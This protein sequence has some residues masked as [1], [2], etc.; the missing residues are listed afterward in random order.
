MW[1]N[2]KESQ[3]QIYMTPQPFYMNLIFLSNDHSGQRIKDS[4]RLPE[5]RDFELLH[6]VFNLSLSAVVA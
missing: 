2:G 4:W 5:I 6:C 3:I 1:K